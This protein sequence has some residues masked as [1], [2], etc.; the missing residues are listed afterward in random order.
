[1]VNNVMEIKKPS[2][3]KPL[4][5]TLIAVVVIAILAGGFLYYRQT[6][7][8]SPVEDARQQKA[9]ENKEKQNFIETTKPDGTQKQTNSNDTSSSDTQISA[10]TKSEANGTVTVITKLGAIS[11]GSCALDVRN[12]DKHINK[13]A[14]V[15]YQ[16]QY[17]SCAGFSITS[18]EKAALGLGEWTI[19]LS[20]VSNGKTHTSKTSFQAT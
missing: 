15:I 6:L 18:S 12:G 13:V 4:I 19:E 3:K 20:V 17:S 1:M 16:E 5:I 9:Q 11:S 8:S 10:S 14:P 7:P 2:G